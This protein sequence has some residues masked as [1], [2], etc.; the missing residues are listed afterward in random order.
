M[1][2]REWCINSSVLHD[3]GLVVVEGISRSAGQADRAY[4]VQVW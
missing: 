4:T 1:A 2:G 3:A